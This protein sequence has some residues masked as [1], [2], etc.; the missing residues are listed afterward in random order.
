VL[1]REILPYRISQRL[2][3]K[4]VFVGLLQIFFNNDGGRNAEKKILG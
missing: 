3:V 2:Q 4:Q 1:E